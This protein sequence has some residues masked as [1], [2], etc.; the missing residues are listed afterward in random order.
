VQYLG[1]KKRLAKRIAAILDA[2]R[3]DGQLFIDMFC[4]S[5]AISAAM[6]NRGPAIANDAC[7]PLINM[8]KAWREGWRPPEHVSEELYAELK[9]KQD[10][11]DPLTAFAGFGF[12]F[13]LSSA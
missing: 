13:A 5:L 11:N 1:G 6:P 8:Y 7:V 10:P 2:E 4:G 12:C 9:A 3:S